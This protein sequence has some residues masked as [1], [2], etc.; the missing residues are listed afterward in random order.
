MLLDLR[1]Q[2]IP[3]PMAPLEV[4]PDL[5]SIASLSA[6]FGALAGYNVVLVTLDTTRPDRIGLYGNSDIETPT[7][8]RLAADGIVFS[9]AVATSSTTL[10]THASILTGLYPWRHGART[11]ALNRLPQDRTTLAELLAR[12]GYDTAAFISS[13]VLDERFG[14]A[15][16]FSHYDDD[17]GLPTSETHDAERRGDQTTERAISWLAKTRSRPFFAWVHYHDP[18][19]NY[20]APRP[21]SERNDHAYDAEIAFVDSQLGRL[22]EAVEAAGGSK[23]LLVV[24]A[25][26]G[27]ALGERGEWTHGFLVQEATIRIP[28]ILHAPEGLGGGY[29]VGT[30]VSQVDLFPTIAALL[31][32]DSPPNLDGVDLARPPDSG[33]MIYAEAVYGQANYGWAPLAAV[34]R[35]RFKYVEGPHPELFDLDQDPLENRNLV[36]DLSAEAGE[37]R[38]HVAALR[39]SWGGVPASSLVALDEED[40]ARLEALGYAVPT[41]DGNSVVENGP[42]PNEMIPIMARLLNLVALA[43]EDAKL[44]ALG[45]LLAHATG[46]TVL[47]ER[48]KLIAELEKLSDEHPDFSPTWHYLAFYYASEARIDDAERAKSRFRELTGKPLGGV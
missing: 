43:E 35:G 25:D 17:T 46:R 44:S 18:H 32:V 34:Y 37:L 7:L 15:Q 31:G 27:E 40:I 33:R 30:R 11:N 39:K 48:G 3:L 20:Q 41:G 36:A 5:E 13:F 29:H 4:S 16:G 10:P 42:D 23:T 45:R 6:P 8:D 1:P 21:F 9:N 24:V 19:A 22:V 12:G 28:M 14:L 38:R 47:S 26:H 2:R